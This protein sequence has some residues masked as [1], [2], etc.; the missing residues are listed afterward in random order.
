MIEGIGGTFI[1][2]DDAAMLAAWY[3]DVLGIESEQYGPGTF[4]LEFR[5]R[6][7]AGRGRLT[8]TVWAIFQLEPGEQRA[9]QSF[10]INYRVDS[11]DAMLERIRARGV[12]I[13]KREDTGHGN[14]AWVHDPEGNK[15]ELWEDTQMEE[16]EAT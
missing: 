15:I 7:A 8:R 2:A 3:R 9:P 12:T 4:V 13:D 11:L 6:E 1:H 14:F 5:V 16:P 10:S